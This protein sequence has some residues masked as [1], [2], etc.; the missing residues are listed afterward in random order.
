MSFPTNNQID[1]AIPADG[2]PNRA[3]TA[4]A[5]KEIVAESESRLSGIESGKVSSDDP[6]LTDARSPTGAAGGV[7]AGSYPSP[8]FAVDMATQAELDAGLSAKLNAAEKGA[9][10]GVA[11]LD[12]SGKVPLSHLNV[13]GL[14][15]M[16]AWDASTN[17]PAL[18]DGTGDVGN[19]YKA[20][21]AGTQN[22]GNGPYTFT[23][24][25]WVMYAAG[26]WQ[27]IG[28]HEAV[29]SVNGKTGAV[30]LTASDVGALPS[31]YTPP[32]PTWASVTSKPA[33]FPPTIG[34][35]ST[36]AKAG[37]Y[38][39]TWAQVTSKPAFDTLYAK[40]GRGGLSA[41]I[42]A[43]YLWRNVATSV[44]SGVE[45]GYVPNS[46]SYDYF[47]M[48]SGG[49]LTIPSWATRIRI[50]GAFTFSENPTGYRYV[51]CTI[52]GS[53]FMSAKIPAITGTTTQLNFTS[54]L[55]ST[56]G[57]TNIAI[58][59]YQNSGTTLEVSNSGWINIELFEAN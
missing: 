35:T 2:E 59:L 53:V 43:A 49:I 30:V 12:S 42:Q 47:S 45:T 50:A 32:A 25:D 55:W 29:A 27:R 19:F 57:R 9:N 36:T 7:L 37:D 17:T 23:E 51:G 10:S 38:Q 46:V 24:G 15:F 33:T 22:F 1:A 39:P 41:P 56:A 31:G 52:D 54:P 20:S 28:V 3:L 6:R 21:A 11:P 48:L 5:I 13:S 18:L 34:T 4:T 8:G 14:S 40:K 16:G 26:T 58:N 44:P